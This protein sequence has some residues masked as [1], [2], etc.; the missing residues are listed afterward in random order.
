MSGP[1]AFGLE[2]FREPACLRSAAR[3]YAYRNPRAAK[4]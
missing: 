4:D 1:T 2:A 3:Y